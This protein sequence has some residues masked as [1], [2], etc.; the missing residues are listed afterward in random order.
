VHILYSSDDNKP[1]KI[2]LLLLL[3]LIAAVA[4]LSIDYFLETIPIFSLGP[5]RVVLMFINMQSKL[6][7]FPLG[8]HNPNSKIH[9]ANFLSKIS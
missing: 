7:L 9:K 8:H 6:V 3:V 1:Y 5:N 4:A 2:T